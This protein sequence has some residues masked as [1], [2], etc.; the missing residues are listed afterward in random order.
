[1][2]FRH[3]RPWLLFCLPLLLLAC[4]EQSGED[5]VAG[6]D[7]LLLDATGPAPAAVIEFFWY[8][9][10]HCHE[11]EPYLN[12]WREDRAP[13]GLD[14]AK[15]PAIY[16]ELTRLH[17]RLFFAFELVETERDLHA[18]LFAALHRERRR[19]EDLDAAAAFLAAGAGISPARAKALLVS[20]QVN[21]AV[22][23]AESL[24]RH[25]RISA[26]PSLV[27]R[28]RYLITPSTAGGL[29]RMLVIADHLLSERPAG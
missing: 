3:P 27:I 23:E 5:F 20:P 25:Y 15:L 11:F 10:P 17:A 18:A 7:Y 26:V 4:T 12:D 24:F 13:R 1:M 21:D 28:G 9:C 29:P 22:R 14:V 19:I 16:N 2:S 8:G 6:R